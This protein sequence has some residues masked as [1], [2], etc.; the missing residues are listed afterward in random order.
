[1]LRPGAISEAPPMNDDSSARSV[2]GLKPRLE[3]LLLKNKGNFALVLR[4]Y[5]IKKCV[6][7][8]GW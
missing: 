1:M 5:F 3:L 4:K 8:N 6:D 2:R 7:S